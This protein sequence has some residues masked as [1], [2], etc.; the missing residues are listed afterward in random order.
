M[1]LCDLFIPRTA[2]AIG[3]RD[4]A[5]NFPSENDFVEIPVWPISTPPAPTSS[6][7]SRAAD[8]ERHAMAEAVSLGADK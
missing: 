2:A 6:P 7:T 5:R 1:K 4:A 3:A 8:V